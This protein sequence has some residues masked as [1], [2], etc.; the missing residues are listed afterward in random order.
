[1]L[2]KLGQVE[3]LANVKT[4]MHAM[5]A[6]RWTDVDQIREIIYGDLN[7]ISKLEALNKMR[8]H[9]LRFTNSTKNIGVQVGW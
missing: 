4:N 2:K 7:A 9:S 6:G 3:E 5:E 1:M 8:S